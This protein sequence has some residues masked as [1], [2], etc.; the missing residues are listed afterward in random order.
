MEKAVHVARDDL[1]RPAHRPGQRQ[2]VRPP[3]RSTTTARRPRSRRWPRSTSPRRGWRSSSPTTRSQLG[4]IE[5]AIRDSDLG[6]NPTNDGTI[7]RVVFPQ[8]TE[9]RRRDLVKVARSKGEDAKVSIRIVR[10]HAKDDARQAGRRTARPARTTCPAPRRSSRAPP[11]RTSRRSTRWSRPRKPSCSRSE[12]PTRGLAHRVLDPG[13]PWWRRTWR[14]LPRRTR[15]RR[16]VGRASG[17]SAAGAP[18]VGGTGAAGVQPAGSRAG[19]NLPLAIGV[20]LLMGAVIIVSL[21][22][23]RQIWIAIVAVSAVIGTWEVFGALQPRGRHPPLARAGAHRR[24]G[25]DLAVVA[26]RHRGHPRVA[27]GHRARL[28]RVADAPGRGGLRPRRRRRRCSCSSDV[29]LC[30]AGSARCWWCPRDGAARVLTFLIIVVCSDTGGY[31]AGVL[32]GKHPMAPKISPKKSWEGLAG[33]MMPACRG[34]VA[35]DR[36]GCSTRT[37]G[38]ACILGPLLVCT[39]VI[40]DLVE[41]LVKRDSASRTWAHAPRPRRAHGAA[42]LAASPPRPWRGCCCSCS[43]RRCMSVTLPGSD[44]EPE[45][46]A[47]ARGLRG[48][49]RRPGRDRRAVGGPRGGRAPRGR[50]RGGRRVRRRLPPAAVRDEGPAAS[51]ASNPTRRWW[52]GRV[53]DARPSRR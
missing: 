52:S 2:R 12:Q 19:R 5:K 20:G 51:P 9:E 38:T 7:I 3:R 14:G 39:A 33:S 8:L 4:A 27:A 48:R 24:S 44:R 34:R 31:A 36:C 41:S 17:P 22:T 10:R 13:G 29:P 35:V 50:R 6:V 21:L 45:H 26:V 30:M 40:G 47:L 16:R 46:L 23:V 49:E 15:R 53:A 43:S 32:F 1:A 37:G 25:H 18:A 42:G 28:L 11:P